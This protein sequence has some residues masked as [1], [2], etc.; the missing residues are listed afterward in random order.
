MCANAG[1]GVNM[2]NVSRSVAAFL[3]SS[4]SGRRS[5]LLPNIRPFGT[6]ASPLLDALDV[7]SRSESKKER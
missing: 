5:S 7:S 3:N 1:G 4:S 2:N 6:K